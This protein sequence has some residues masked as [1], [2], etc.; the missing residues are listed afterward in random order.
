ML[1]VTNTSKLDYVAYSDEK[2]EKTENIIFLF[3][4]WDG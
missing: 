3:K 2:T 1:W 4:V